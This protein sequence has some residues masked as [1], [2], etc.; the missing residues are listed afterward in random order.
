MTVKRIAVPFEIKDTPSQDGV[1]SGYGSVFGVTDWYGDVVEP[2]AFGKSLQ[3]WAEKGKSP[4]ML[5][6]HDSRKPIGK[7]T[8]LAE[9]AKG[10]YVEGKLA[11]KTRDGADAYEHLKEGT[12]SGLSIGFELPKGGGEWDPK[13]ETFRLKQIDLWEVSP[14][15]FPANEAAQVEAVKAALDN[16]RD[17][18]RQL[19]DVLGLTQAQ[20]KKLMAGGFKAL[21]TRDVDDETAAVVAAAAEIRSRSI[22][23]LIHK[24]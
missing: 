12:I 3:L 7:W 17:F 8:R 23:S 18:E 11:L 9:D 13:S 6:Q 20:A 16:P 14:V 15:T 4:A 19:R 10:L 24:E 5:W 22:I 1:F 21:A 2:G